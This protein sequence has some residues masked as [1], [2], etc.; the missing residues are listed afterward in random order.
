MPFSRRELLTAGIAAPFVSSCA[1]RRSVD[2]EET[3]SSLATKLGISATYVTLAAGN[4]APAVALSNGSSRRVVHADSLFQAA[5]LTKP[6]IAFVALALARE[7]KLDLGAPVSRYLPSGY[8]HRQNPGS[9]P[10]K[11]DLVEASML[12]SIPVATLLNHSSGLPNWSGSTLRPGFAAGQRWS[13][14]GEAYVLLHAIISAITGQDIDTVV[15]NYVFGP[16]EMRR[17]GMRLTEG[18]RDHLAGS[19]GWL[20]WA[21]PI[22][23]IEANAAASLYTTATDYAKLMAHWV[24]DDELLALTLARPVSVDQRLGL[25]W[26]YGWGMEIAAGGPYLWQWGNNPGYRAFA[27]ISASSGNGF[28]LLTNSEQGMKLAEPL[29]RTA[30]PSEHGAFRFYMLA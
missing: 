26:G 8:R 14:S 24:G 30:I 15:D 1:M 17:S 13:Y 11:F 2:S 4:P 27:M 6:V 18:M 7:G 10:P 21:R 5:S 25:S 20:P 23:F 12:A 16:L 19:T 22:E 29:A 3:V 9:N 28:V